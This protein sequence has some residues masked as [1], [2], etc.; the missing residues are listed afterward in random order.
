MQLK[1]QTL[2]F[3]TLGAFS[4]PFASAGVNCN[5]SPQCGVHGVDHIQG[6][7]IDNMV[8][9]IWSGIPDDHVYK[10]GEW[11]ACATASATENQ[12]Y[13]CAFLQNVRKSGV[14]AQYI[15]EAIWDLRAH[16]CHTCGGA[17]FRPGTGLEGFLTVN[18]VSRVEGDKC[19]ISPPGICAHCNKN[20]CVGSYED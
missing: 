2:I 7:L 15:K 17:P 16:G 13:Y 5:G 18:Y 20:K 8:N 3:A 10:N 19:K 1:L 12:Y 9:W 4:L 11:I 14:N 6:W